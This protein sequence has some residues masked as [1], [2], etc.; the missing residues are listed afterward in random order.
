LEE[1]LKKNTSELAYSFRLN[2][3]ISSS[4][5]NTASVLERLGRLKDARDFYDLALQA[6]ENEKKS[7][8]AH[9]PGMYLN[10]LWKRGALAHRMGEWDV[11]EASYEASLEGSLDV[12]DELEGRNRI[13]LAGIYMKQSRYVDAES[14]LNRALS[15]VAAGEFPK[16]EWQAWFL[17]GRLRR[18]SHKYDAAFRALENSI[19]VLE[20][21]IGRAPSGESRQS[22][23]SSR[24]DPYREMVSLLM[25][26]RNDVTLAA[27]FADRCKS[28]A[29][30]EYLEG[31]RMNAPILDEVPRSASSL[32]P[33]TCVGL[34]FFFTAEELFVFVSR[35]ET[36]NAITIEIDPDRAGTLVEKFLESIEEKNA[37]RYDAFSVE[38]H[39]KIVEPI[40]RQSQL[41]GAEILLLFPDGPLHRLPFAALKDR[42]GRFLIEEYALSYAPSQSVFD[43]CLALNRSNAGSKMRTVALLDGSG[44]LKSAGYEIAFISRLY[45]SHALI[46][47]PENLAEA[48]RF[49]AGAEIFHFAGHAVVTDGKPALM[50]HR[51]SDRILIDAADI[52]SWDLGNCRLAYL[53]GCNTGLGPQARGTAPWGL[54]PAF[55]G[56]G[57]PAMIVSLGP[58]DDSVTESLSRHFYGFLTE[59]PLAKAKALQKAQLALLQ[60]T[61]PPNSFSWIPYV[62]IG[63][64]L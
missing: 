29:L 28:I 52:H 19:G 47:K 4:F 24:V 64:P 43:Y 8:V 40:L 59:G 18:E 10:L 25:N 3:E 48:G 53:A 46:L 7:G 39:E 54:V 2:S 23:A 58:V 9:P 44:N 21:L 14:M 51:G 17:L 22:F 60:S 27:R 11:A 13:G 6:H 35:G 26:H 30:R 55:L 42:S 45:G 56:A 63:D 38:L 41:K 5:Y 49:T 50:L 16:L 62:L 36:V 32:L 57:A 61:D 34:E 33:E 1:S 15:V 12:M 31:R 20:T 37:E